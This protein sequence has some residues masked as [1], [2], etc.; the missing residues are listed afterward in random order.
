MWEG[1]RSILPFLPTHNQRCREPGKLSRRRS[2]RLLWPNAFR[3]QW[4]SSAAGGDAAGI[5]ADL[6]G[7][8]GGRLAAA[9]VAEVTT[10]S[11][12]LL[13]VQFRAA[14]PQAQ[15]LDR[16]LERLLA[17]PALRPLLGRP[18]APSAPSAARIASRPR[19]SN[20]TGPTS[21]S[22][23]WPSGRGDTPRPGRSAC[24]RSR[25]SPR[26][27]RPSGRSGGG[28]PSGGR[29][30]GRRRW[31]C[32]RRGGRAWSR[33]CPAGHRGCRLWARL[34]C[35]RLRPRSAGPCPPAVACR[36]ASSPVSAPLPV[37]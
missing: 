12:S 33:S 2:L 29:P 17:P 3:A 10:L 37:G 25:G 18:R 8:L 21:P 11:F 22:S 23:P 5:L 28:E 26:R 27:R 34:G 30:G 32:P 35:A 6:L 16:L 14:R 9:G 31:D 1:K 15:A 7:P 19:G 4:T 20:P 24:G 13:T 36:P